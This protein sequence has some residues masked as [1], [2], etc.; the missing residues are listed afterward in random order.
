VATAFDTSAKI[1]LRKKW[2]MSRIC[3]G[4]LVAICLIVS[5][6]SQNDNCVTVGRNL[7]ENSGQ[8]ADLADRLG[9]PMKD[10]E[11]AAIAGAAWALAQLEAGQQ[12]TSVVICL[13]QGDD[14]TEFRVS[15]TAGKVLGEWRSVAGFLSTAP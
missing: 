14:D 7:I 11:A 9:L 6:C 2:T 8:V 1:A 4:L 10:L 13:R 5:S 12:G 15:N 3:S